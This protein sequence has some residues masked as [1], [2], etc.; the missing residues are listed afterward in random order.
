MSN[1]TYEMA[2]VEILEIIK[3]LP[4]AEQSK[5]PKYKIEFYE[6]HKDKNYNFK[7][8]KNVSIEEQRLLR[9]T[10]II[11]INLFRDFFAND[12]Q[13]QKLEI[14]LKN[15]SKLAEEE[16]RQKYNPNDIFK[17]RKATNIERAGKDGQEQVNE[18]YNKSLPI[19]IRKQN[20]FQKLLRFV[21]DLLNIN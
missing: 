13:K 6:K 8:D 5:I 10:R 11:M 21:K 3:Y 15:N 9:K 17:N 16:R 12:I 1:D 19:E 7:F 2:Y 20:I 4:I 14:I 18:E